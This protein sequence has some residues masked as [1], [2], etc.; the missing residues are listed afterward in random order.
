[1]ERN[2]E[3][4]GI[5]R[6]LAERKL[7]Q[8][9]DG[10]ESFCYKHPELKLM[11]RLEQIK[12]DSSLMADYWQRGYKDASLDT[13]YNRLIVRTYRLAADAALQYGVAHNSFL[14]TTYRRVRDNG[15]DEALTASA[16]DELENF[17][18]NI[19][20]L[21]LEPEHVR[22]ER[23]KSLYARHQT[24]LN[25]LFDYIWT[26]EQWTDG[27]TDTLRRL[28]LSPTVD[29]ADQQLIVSAVTL[30]AMNIFDINKLHLLADTYKGNADEAVR[31][32]ALVGFVFAIDGGDA[33]LFPDMVAIVD[34]LLRDEATCVALSELQLQL[35][36]CLS[37]ES[38]TRKVQSEIMPE[39]IKNNNISVNHNGIVERDD[40][41]MEDIIDPEA[42]ERRME[43]IEEGFRKIGDMQ[44]AGA[45][46]YFG[47]F[48]RMKNFP[49]FS[50]ASNWFTVYYSEHPAIVSLYDKKSDSD[51]VNNMVKSIPFCSS[52]KY[53]FVIAFK[54]FIGR[55]PQEMREM[56]ANGSVK[57]IDS[58]DVQ[59]DGN[60]P[61]YQRRT[62]L[63]DFY[64]FLRLFHS[65]GCFND[66]FSPQTDN[67]CHGYVFFANPLL[68]GT[69]LGG[70]FN[71][72][73]AGMV[74][75]RFFDEAASVLANY[76]DS[77][78]DYLYYML[79]GNLILQHG[80]IVAKHDIVTTSATDSYRRA[81]GMKEG[82]EKAIFGYARA[83]FYEGEYAKAA[84]AYE[85]LLAMKPESKRYELGLCVCLINTGR[86]EEAQKTL[87][88][89]NYDSPDDDNVSRVLA[90]SLVGVGKYEQAMK[91]YETLDKESEDLV[92][93]GYCEWFMGDVQAAIG[94]FADYI[95]KRY[96]DS[97]TETKRR[98]CQADVIDSERDFIR[99]HGISD[100]ETHL[101]VDA[102]RDAIVR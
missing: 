86:Y 42:S 12:A 82:D 31:Q 39:I 54:S 5:V 53:S 23:M 16:V 94:H 1:M 38:D 89:L 68:S 51:L 81:M 34:D 84:E 9:I 36:Y 8:A 11:Q 91:L 90:R 44:R 75:R 10:L 93:R 99:A 46:I 65:R 35:L 29:A 98:H 60:D 87:Y 78:K 79:C 100:T 17:V 18:S 4:E 92:N 48:A 76:A 25:D 64:R 57:A 37:A 28:L 62:Y 27:L 26:S 59:Q 6:M 19:A 24:F 49:F 70:H 61:A 13:V 2:K 50:T 66:P 63:Q 58:I 101:M 47:G 56:M 14:V 102:I 69:L 15:R 95:T 45:D 41:P 33:R 3:I 21:E 77:D 67:G 30:G 32:R 74:K 52:D 97:D 83:L 20:L 43:K 7:R 22:G 88:R 40:D 55:L 96:P 85:N 80:D 73:V 71:A 72:V